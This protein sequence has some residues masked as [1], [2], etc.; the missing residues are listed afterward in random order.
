MTTLTI[1]P[2]KGTSKRLS[3]K[4]ILN[5]YGKSLVQ[6]AYDAALESGV[7]GD[8][9]VSTEDEEIAQHARELGAWLPFIRPMTLSVDP[10]GVE[11]VA[12]YC[13]FELEKLGHVYSKLIILLPTCPLRNSQDIKCANDKFVESKALRLMSVSEYDHSPFSSWVIKGDD[14]VAPL[15]EEHYKKKSQQLERVYRCNGAIHILDVDE[16]KKTE[17]YTMQ[18]LY[19]YI[20]PRDRGVDIDTQDDWTYALWLMSK[21]NKVELA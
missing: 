14:Q 2:A 4:N 20:M 19:S 15:F 10:A 17:S 18:P 5:M 1:I 21:K 6:H 11:T 3:R 7:C 13:L 16:F 12:L 8:V 9:M